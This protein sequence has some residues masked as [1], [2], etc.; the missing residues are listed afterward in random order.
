MSKVVKVV[1]GKKNEYGHFIGREYCF[2]ADDEIKK[3]DLVVVD[4]ANGLG[5]GTVS[6]DAVHTSEVAKATRWVVCKVDIE[7][8]NERVAAEE[9][10]KAIMTKMEEMKK[11]I[12][13]ETIFEILAEKNSDMK[14]LLEEYKAIKE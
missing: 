3:D 5:L 2:K 1:F 6:N 7:K 10:K 8:H 13:E 12:E 4:T 14:A 9:R 11:K